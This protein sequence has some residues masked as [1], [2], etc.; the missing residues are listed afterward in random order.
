MRGEILQLKETLDAIV[1]SFAPESH[2]S[3]AREV[4]SEGRLGGQ[5]NVPGVA[6]RGKTYRLGQCDGR[7][8][9]GAVVTRQGHHGRSPRHIVAQHER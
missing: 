1:R 5:A 8:P 3:S 9:H 4:G 7:K 2:A 6:A